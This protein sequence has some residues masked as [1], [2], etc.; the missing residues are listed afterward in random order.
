[1]IHQKHRDVPP[2]ILSHY[3]V[4][5][6]QFVSASFNGSESSGEILVNIVVTRAISSNEINVMI[7]L[8][9]GSATS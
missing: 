1:M 2:Y 7:S 5:K 6:I 9:E 8:I 3:V 4:V